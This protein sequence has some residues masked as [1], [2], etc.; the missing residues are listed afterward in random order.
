MDCSYFSNWSYS[1]GLS[2]SM[3]KGLGAVLIS[4]SRP[5]FV[6][7]LPLPLLIHSHFYKLFGL[8]V[9]FT[10][11]HLYHYNSYCLHLAVRRSNTFTA[12]T[13][14][15][16]EY[17]DKIIARGVTI[18]NEIKQLRESHGSKCQFQTFNSRLPLIPSSQSLQNRWF[19]RVLEDIKDIRRLEE[20][21]PS[22]LS[23]AP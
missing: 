9:S 19:S 1:R 3:G 13:M 6:T 5:F 18:S 4:S 12:S 21:L 14:D 23:I 10:P 8:F 11:P 15:K 2:S 17:L 22:T 20:F 7:F 16:R